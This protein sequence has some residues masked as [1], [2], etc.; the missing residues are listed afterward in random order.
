MAHSCHPISEASSLLHLV[1]KLKAAITFS[2]KG[3]KTYSKCIEDMVC[4]RLNNIQVYRVNSERNSLPFFYYLFLNISLN[5]VSWWR[6]APV[7]LY[8]E[9]VV[10]SIEVNMRL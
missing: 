10:G 5:L 3:L 6:V 9:I 4:Q 1:D 8:I 7:Q 2:I